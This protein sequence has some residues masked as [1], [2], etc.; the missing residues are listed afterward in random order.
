MFSYVQ[1]LYGVHFTSA[2]QPRVL[3][4]KSVDCAAIVLQE[5]PWS[6]R[7]RAPSPPPGICTR[8]TRL[9]LGAHG[10]PM[11]RVCIL[12]IF[13]ICLFCCFF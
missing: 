4:T 7:S 1:V 8:C 10:F 11:L 3:P 9:T 12:G 13:G 5:S 2:V 6:L